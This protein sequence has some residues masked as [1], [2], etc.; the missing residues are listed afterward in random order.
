MEKGI[1]KL[2]KNVV[3]RNKIGEKNWKVN[4]DWINRENT[5]LVLRFKKK[6]KHFRGIYMYILWKIL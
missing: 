1:E 3:R 6:K 4:F 2:E 5:N